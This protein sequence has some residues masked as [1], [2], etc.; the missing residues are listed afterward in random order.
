MQY[1]KIIGNPYN[2]IILSFKE[3]YLIKDTVTLFDVYEKYL[4]TTG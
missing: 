1:T 3:A 4:Q 2:C